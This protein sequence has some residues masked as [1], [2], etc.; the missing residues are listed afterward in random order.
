[1]LRKALAVVFLLLAVSSAINFANRQ[2]ALDFSSPRQAGSALAVLML[3]AISLR[4]WS[5]SSR[6]PR[7]D[8]DRESSD[9]D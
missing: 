7:R 2:E 6:R 3:L 4:L 8:T 9:L 1:M 5:R